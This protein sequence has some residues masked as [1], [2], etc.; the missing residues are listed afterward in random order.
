[1]AR[2]WFVIENRNKQPL[3]V[4]ECTYQRKEVVRTMAESL[5]G[6]LEVAER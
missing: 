1:M 3:G 6:T 2:I 4:P 5:Y